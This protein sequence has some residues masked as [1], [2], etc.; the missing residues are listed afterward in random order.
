MTAPLLGIVAVLLA[1]CDDSA[2]PGAGPP[3]MLPQEGDPAP[4]FELPASNGSSVALHRYRG[5]P[6]LLYFS[7]GPG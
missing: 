6:V 2:Q 5:R 3:E 7:M 4:E 1:A